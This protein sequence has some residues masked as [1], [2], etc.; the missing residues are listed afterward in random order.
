MSRAVPPLAMA[1]LLSN[2]FC[3]GLSWWP[4]R[5]LQTLGLHPLWATV[6]VDALVLGGIVCMQPQVLARVLGN[7]ALWPLLIAAGCTNVGFN[8]S[9][10]ATW[11]VWCSCFI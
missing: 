5:Q 7:R 10:L 1:A 3:Y 6:L 11:C 4:F 8:L 9:P 2:A